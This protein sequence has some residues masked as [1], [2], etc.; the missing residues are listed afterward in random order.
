M[1]MSET[2]GELATALAK[3]QG[4]IEAAT[5]GAANSHFNSKYADLS[6]V[7]EAV[8]GPLLSQGIGIMQFV[9]DV[10]GGVEGC[11]ESSF[12]QQICRPF[13]RH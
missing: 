5:K 11:E 9:G 4:Q 1:N 12:Q 3:A 7:I 10:E 6:S 2:I 8:K 13:Q